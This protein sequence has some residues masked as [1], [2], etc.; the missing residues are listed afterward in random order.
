L[1]I[2]GGDPIFG[3]QLPRRRLGRENSLAGQ[4]VAANVVLVTLTLFG[5]SLAA[6]LDITIQEQRWQ[7]AVL[8]LAVVLTL[9]VNLWMLKRRFGP[10]DQ[11]IDRIERVDPSQPSSFALRDE[12]VAEIDRLARSFKRLLQRVEAERTRT[13]KLVL[14]AQEEERRRLARDLHDE[15]NQALTAIL[16]RLEAASHAAPPELEDELGE[17]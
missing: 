8:A 13:G 5:A 10:L 17:L 12:A 16:L 14:R 7:F 3:M 2:W 6:G 9:C 11:L 4:V 1:P 15:V